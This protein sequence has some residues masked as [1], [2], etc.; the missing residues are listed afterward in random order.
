M[1]ALRYPK[2]RL[3]GY[4]KEMHIGVVKKCLLQTSFM[5]GTLRTV[6]PHGSTGAGRRK[7]SGPTGGRAYGIPVKLTYS[8]GEGTCAY[9]FLG[10]IS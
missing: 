1:S 6:S 4:Q 10:I 8:W 2:S 5:N 3:L 9:D 7:R